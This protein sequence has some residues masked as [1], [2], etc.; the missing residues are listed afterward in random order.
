MSFLTA[1][2]SLKRTGD[3]PVAPKPDPLVLPKQASPDTVDF[4]ALRPVKR[5]TSQ[6]TNPTSVDFSS[7]K[8]KEFEGSFKRYDFSENS[9]GKKLEG[10]DFEILDGDGSVIGAVQAEDIG[11]GVL[12][13]FNSSLE[14]AYRG[15]GIGKEAYTRLLEAARERG[16]RRVVSDS[17]VSEDAI[18]VWESLGAVKG[19]GGVEEMQRGGSLDK[20]QFYTKEETPLY[21]ITLE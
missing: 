20:K 3:A 21:E 6:G 13:V 19:K 17:S 14:T 18:R 7:L 15:R 12:Q 2:K 4:N 8:R 9:S 16:F 10:L 11:D 1:L 5:E